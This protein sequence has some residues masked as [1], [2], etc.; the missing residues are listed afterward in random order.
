VHPVI[1]RY[2]KNDEV[3]VLQLSQKYASWDFTP[4]EAD[5]QGFHSS[6]PDFFLVAEAQPKNS[7]LVY[8]M[9]QRTFPKKS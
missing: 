4:T 8:A 3:E 1:R 6:E 9:S 2:R 7:W 5:I